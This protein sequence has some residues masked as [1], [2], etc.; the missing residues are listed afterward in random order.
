M[1][2]FQSITQ[3][4]GNTPLVRLQRLGAFYSCLGTIYGKCEF[5]NPSGSLKD[6]PSLDIIRGAI[7]SGEL[8][9]DGNVICIS[10][11]IGGI[12]TAMICACLGYKCIVVASD[13]IT[14]ENLRHIRAYG[15]RVVMT[16][17][18]LGLKGMRKKAE[19]IFES[20]EG[21]FILNQ[22]Y[23]PRNP[24]S[25]KRTTGPEILSDLPET[26]CFVAG[27]GTGGSVTGCGEY[28]KMNRPE[29]VIIGVEPYDSPVLSGGLPGPHCITGIGPGF[30]PETLN[31]YILDKVVRVRTP[32]ALTMARRLASLEGM[33][34]GP[35][36]GAALAAAIFIA[37][38]ED[39]AER[40]IVV[41]LPD[42]GERYLER[43][44][45]N[46]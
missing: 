35:S 7:S 8:R 46:K 21:S 40:N 4:I 25:Y 16:S 12:S 33:L 6:H 15:A 30:V 11:G 36:S 34:C 32:D 45:Y 10:N 2:V 43:E 26:D 41:L 13:N 31:K 14:L 17:S 24:A 44:I 1:A 42:R 37:Q 9:E 5:L 28:L 19:E 39:F 29:C 18:T 3:L 27:I 23:D 22:F 20:R 38:Q